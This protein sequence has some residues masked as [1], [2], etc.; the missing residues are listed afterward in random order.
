MVDF[1]AP[2]VIYWSEKIVERLDSI[3]STL[4]E[5]LYEIKNLKKNKEVWYWSFI[6]KLIERSTD[7]TREVGGALT[8]VVIG[9]RR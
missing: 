2:P 5:I 7:F 9:T 3:D 1:N 4:K 8:D 6:E